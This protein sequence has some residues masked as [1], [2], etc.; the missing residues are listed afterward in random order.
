ML[1]DIKLDIWLLLVDQLLEP[2]IAELVSVFKLAIVLREL[3]NSIVGE[4]D[5]LVVDVLQID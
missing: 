5:E 3:L 1:V 4:M 2:L